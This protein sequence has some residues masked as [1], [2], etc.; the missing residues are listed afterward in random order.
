MVASIIGRDDL[1]LVT[2]ATGFI[3][4]RVVES[5]LD[6]GFRNVRCFARPSSDVGQ[7][8]KPCLG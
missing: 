5:L 8:S 7:G 2:G 1:I 4:S 6:L 3:G